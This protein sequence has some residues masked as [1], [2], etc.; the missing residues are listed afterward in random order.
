MGLGSGGTYFGGG[1]GAGSSSSIASGL[2]FAFPTTV[3]SMSLAL[4]RAL[5]VFSSHRETACALMGL[6]VDSVGRWIDL[7]SSVWMCR[8]T[9][10]IEEQGGRRVLVGDG[11]QRVK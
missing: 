8:W 4:G 5:G 9:V 1:G 10:K 11:S 2:G 7:E 3:T 6:L